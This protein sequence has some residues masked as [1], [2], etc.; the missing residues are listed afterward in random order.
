MSIYFNGVK[1]KAAVGGL[2]YNAAF[3]PPKYKTVNGIWK[4]NETLS[5]ENLD[6]SKFTRALTD[7]NNLAYVFF[8]NYT[9]KNSEDTDVLYNSLGFIF[10]LKTKELVYVGYTN[11][12][13]YDINTGTFDYNEYYE[14]S[15][16]NIASEKWQYNQ[17]DIPD[18]DLDKLLTID[19]GTI[20][21]KIP[22]SFYNWFIENATAVA[23]AI[24]SETGEGMTYIFNINDDNI[25]SES[26]DTGG[27]TINITI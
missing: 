20:F 5:F 17:I 22:E 2:I 6:Y 26:N 15:M 25:S 13:D 27:T 11:I 21:Q 14:G 7:S 24:P 12:R 23:A 4:L 3:V 1:Y 9:S 10:D 16:Y 8:V 19:L 18:D